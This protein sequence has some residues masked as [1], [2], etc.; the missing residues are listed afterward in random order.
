MKSNNH[1][2]YS[3]H[4][5][6]LIRMVMQ[7]TGDVLELGTG[8]FSTPV[9]H[10]MCVPD[11]RNLVSYESNRKF[12]ELAKQ[13]SHKF[14][15]IRYA[16]NFENI[17]I[18]RPWDVVFI[19][20]EVHEAGD[21]NR[22]AKRAANYAKFV[23]LHDT[24]WRDRRHHHYEEIYPLYKYRYQFHLTRPKTTVVSNFVDV[25]ELGLW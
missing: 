20:H 11:K 22:T 17:E 24:C 25:N 5:P 4:L 7:T 15:T 3:S 14:H 10:W 9:L 16:E 13:Y 8:M 23:I 2:Y 18:E 1:V 12:Y 6:L 19:D 21:R